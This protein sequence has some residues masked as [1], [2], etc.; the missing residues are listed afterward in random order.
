[1]F[2]IKS[3]GL[4]FD[5]MPGCFVCGGDGGMFRCI[6]AEVA[7]KDI[8]TVSALFEAG[9]VQEAGGVK[10]GACD[11]HRRQLIT[12]NELIRDRTIDPDKIYDAK[13]A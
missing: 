4:A 10:V 3:M 8:G 5:N 6:V 13:V 11:D 1:M 7:A 9:V 12:L 2:D